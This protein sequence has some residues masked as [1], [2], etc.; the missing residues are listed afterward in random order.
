MQRF[1]EKLRMLRTRRQMTTR[2]LALALGY[3][4][5]SNSYISLIENGKQKP[6]LNFVLRTAQFF[7]VSADRL[8]R[9]DLELEIDQELNSGAE[10]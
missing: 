5:H 9:D 2:D 8:T 7:N 10:E 3:T 6:S 1:G 4:A